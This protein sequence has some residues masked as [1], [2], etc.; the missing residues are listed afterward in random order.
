MESFSRLLKK[1]QNEGSLMGVKVSRIV[2]ILHLLFVDDILIMT[3]AFL[4]EWEEINNLL[5]LF[6][7]ATGLKVNMRKS[8]FYHSRF[9]GELL[10]KF[11]D[12]YSYEFFNMVKGIR[13]L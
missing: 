7:S 8:I 5:N 11:K 2:K 3:K 12:G 6:C 13:Y 10:E 1:G 9:Q 4:Q